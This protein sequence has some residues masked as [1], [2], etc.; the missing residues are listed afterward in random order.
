MVTRFVEPQ[1]PPEN[2]KTNIEK[3][4]NPQLQ[5]CQIVKCHT[6]IVK[7]DLMFHEIQPPDYERD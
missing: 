6:V 4:S 2:K 3:K 5:S 7:K 1:H